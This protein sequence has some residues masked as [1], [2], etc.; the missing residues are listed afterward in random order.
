MLT[1]KTRNIKG[2]F[3]FPVRVQNGNTFHVPIWNEAQSLNTIWTPAAVWALPAPWGENMSSFP[4]QNSGLPGK[5]ELACKAQEEIMQGRAQLSINSVDHRGV[6]RHEILIF[7]FDIFQV[8]I[9]LLLLSSLG[10]PLQFPRHPGASSPS[11]D[12]WP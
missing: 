10:L 4:S 5:T 3:G 1:Q 9:S 8:L 6:S 12:I 7:A 2:K 11:Y